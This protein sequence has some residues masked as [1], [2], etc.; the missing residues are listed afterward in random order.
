V[1]GRSRDSWER[2][3]QAGLDILLE[4]GRNAVT[5][6]AVCKRAGVSPTAIYARVDSIDS[7][8]WALYDRGFEEVRRTYLAQFGAALATTPATPERIAAVVHG[9]STMFHENIAFLNPIISKAAVDPVLRARG[10][11]D[12][13]PLVRA[14][15]GLLL[16]D[17]EAA[18]YDTARM[19]MAEGTYRAFFGPDFLTA[20]PEAL[21][22]FESRLEA[23]ARARLLPAE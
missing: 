12:C 5:I 2:I 22:D 19:L 23:M 3:L 17:D 11:E 9:I 15:A 7:L 13:R 1:Q 18:A 8:F 20:E 4:D 6:Q 16:V 21:P 10:T 14:M